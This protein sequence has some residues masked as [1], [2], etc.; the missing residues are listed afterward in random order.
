MA[1]TQTGI[2]TRITNGANTLA[3]DANGSA[4]FQLFDG[5]N[6]AIVSTNGELTVGGQIAIADGTNTLTLDNNGSASVQI[7]KGANLW[8]IDTN[9][10]GLTIGSIVNGTNTLAIDTNGNI[11]VV[12]NETAATPV[13]FYSTSAAVAQ[14]ASV[15]FDYVVTNTKD[16]TGVQVAVGSRGATKVTVSEFDGT[17]AVP[18]MTYFQLAGDTKVMT[19]PG[20]TIAGDATNAVRVSVTNLDSATDLYCSI[21]GN[22]I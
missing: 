21:Y 6:K 3:L 16:F 17:T 11:G 5:T 18:Q 9:G 19:I 15:N 22:E 1:D 10:A 7:F 14:N 8:N 20:I 4:S 12:I 13:F 2:P